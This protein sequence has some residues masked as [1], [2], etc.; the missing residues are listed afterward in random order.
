MEK[1]TLRHIGGTIFALK[2]LL[3]LFFVATV[4]PTLNFSEIHIDQTFF[5]FVFIGFLAQVV[6]AAVGM[7]YG[8]SC[9]TLL[10]NFG[11]SPAVAT[12]S[13]HTAE[14][15]TTGA[16]GL[17]HL[18]FKNIDKK[19]FFRIVI[20]GVLGAMIGAYAISEVFD[21]NWV[22][23]YISLYLIG[24]GSVFLWKG[25]RNKIRETETVKGAE[26]LAFFGGFMD[27]VGGGGW[28]PIVTSNI[29]NQ[30]KCPKETIGTVNIA[31]FFVAFFGT[32][33]FLFFVG[34]EHWQVVL[35]LIVGGVVASP[36]GAYFASHFKRKTLM[37]SA[38]IAIIL[39]SGYS[40]AKALL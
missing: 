36:L 1:I 37:I 12:A 11:I 40:L 26:G 18:K 30:G 38:G 39:L 27:A 25:L 24:L 15:F 5:T 8:A 3:I 21:G 23:P 19:L 22:K 2:L 20:T 32:G 13:V 29:I 35:G 14:V 4:F 10:L 34:I 28:G 16:S 9:T 6:D 33:V 31:E 7:G 17:A